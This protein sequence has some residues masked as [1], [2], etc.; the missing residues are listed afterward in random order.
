MLNLITETKRAGR[1]MKM[2][3]HPNVV[4]LYEVIDT[5]TK[6]YL[7]LE[8]ADGG[9][10]YDYIMKHETGL[11]ENSA[12]FYFRQMYKTNDFLFQFDPKSHS[13]QRVSDL[14]PEN[15]VFFEQDRVVKITDFGF[16]NKFNPGQKLRTSCG[17]L[18]YSAP[19]I[20]LGDFY[21]A[22]SVGK[23]C[24]DLNKLRVL[25]PKTTVSF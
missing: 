21:D 24:K 16:S 13:S 7:V 22:P 2:V 1:C 3:Q 8:L 25:H 23:F 9:D 6:L 5:Q 15:I 10:L 12:R 11:S 17:S 18:A 19:E 4:K 20:L 14:K